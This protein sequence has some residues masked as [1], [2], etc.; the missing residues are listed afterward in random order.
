MGEHEERNLTEELVQ[1]IEKRILSWYDELTRRV[2]WT[3]SPRRKSLLPQA[4]GRRP[5]GVSAGSG[6]TAKDS[7]SKPEWAE[8]RSECLVQQDWHAKLASIFRTTSCGRGCDAF[9]EKARDHPPTKR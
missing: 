9:K 3:P 2:A 7:P 5:D 6:Q 8:T 1:L 4:I